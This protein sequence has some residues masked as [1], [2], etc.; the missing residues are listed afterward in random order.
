MLFKCGVRLEHLEQAKIDL[1]LE[2][3]KQSLSEAGYAK[4]RGAMK[5]NKF[6]GEICERR[7]ILNE[8]SY[9]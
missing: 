9:W 6:L 4:V 1:V 8:H 5:I 2:L 3:L 7:A